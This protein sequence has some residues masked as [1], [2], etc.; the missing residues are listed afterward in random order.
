MTYSTILLSAADLATL[1]TPADYLE[2]VT[3]AFRAE[4]EGRAH[5]P[6]PLHIDGTA[7]VFHGKG[8][9][10][11]GEKAYVVLKFNGN[12]PENPKQNGLHT[13]QGAALLCEAANG[14]L[15]AVMDSIELTLK[16]T[17]AA[18]AL[19]A[20]HLARQDSKAV[21]ICGCGD[22]ALPQLAAL[23]GVLP[24][25]RVY[26]WDIA[27][28]QA[29][30]LA[31]TIGEKLQLEGTVAADMPD[32]VQ[33]SDV[34]V[35]CTT[36]PEPFL[37]PQHIG[38]GT[39]IAAVGADSP[40]KNEIHP[41]LMAMGK[42]VVDSLQQCRVMGDL[43]A[44]IAAGQM[45]EADIHGEL[46]DLV[47]GIKPGREIHNEITIFDSTGTALQDVASAAMVHSRAVASGGGY[48]FVFASE[49]GM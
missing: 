30:K 28:Q 38:P 2:A 19:A 25:E 4:K 32:A 21:T 7:G 10:F 8:A 22:Q 13:I 12:F 34:I 24:L 6:P 48:P 20:R 18:S 43:R 44:A 27:R 47:T 42:V 23:C 46:G 39:F 17:A 45:R 40:A 33:D 16:R 35:T 29:E 9:F 11:L 15:L 49:C 1:M 5:A 41:S 3:E 26:C 36:A 37:M 14:R 31:V